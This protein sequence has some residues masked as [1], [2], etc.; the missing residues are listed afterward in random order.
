MISIAAPYSTRRSPAANE[1]PRF[2]DVGADY[3]ELRVELT[4]AFARVMASGRYVLG[5]ELE[6]FER[7]FAAF[8]DRA[9]GSASATAL[10]RFRSR[11]APATSVQAMR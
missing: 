8:C 1:H 5:E 7:E 4:E 9:M 10:R 3:R 6:V 11:C 2:L